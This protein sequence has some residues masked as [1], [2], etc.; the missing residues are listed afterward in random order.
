MSSGYAIT[1]ALSGLAPSA[2]TWSSGYTTGRDR[3]NDD[4]MDEV[5][6][7]SSSAQASGQY[8]QIDLGSVTEVAA[9]VLL[10]H[11]LASG[12]CAVYID[13]STTAAFTPGPN[14]VTVKAAST[15]T[16]TAP[17]QKD[18]ILQLPQSTTATARYWRIYFTHSGTKTITLG[19]VLFLSSITSLSRSYTYG[20]SESERVVTNRVESVTGSIRSTYVA[21]PIR[22]KRFAFKDAQ[23]ESQRNELMGMWRNT[24]GGTRN[25]LWIDTIEST[26]TAASAAAQTCIWG[27]L[28]D[29]HG[30]TNN[31]YDLFDVDGF[32]LVSQ[33]R[34][35]GS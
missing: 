3:L 23:G 19:E 14:T 22:T 32:E 5:A 18:T 24:R 20:N 27:R 35:V 12:S 30:W 7:G 26:S 11:N 15:I 8:L 2:F 10:N 34:E 28:G 17:N 16:T 33:G 29:T 21:G 31:D 6:S 13:Q 4:L 25:L 1:N 9:I